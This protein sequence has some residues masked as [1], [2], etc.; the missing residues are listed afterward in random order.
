MT[1]SV[2]NLLCGIGLFLCGIFLIS[3]HT[4]NAFGEK[5]QHTLGLLTKNRFTGMLTG[6]IVT[7]IIQSSSAT[8]VMAVSFVSSG[9][10]NLSQATGIVMG[11][12]IG[13][14]V[15]SLLIAFNF[16]K[17]APLAIFF[18][19]AVKIFAKKEQT[20]HICYLVTG[21]GLLFLGMNTMSLA[22]SHLKESEA[23]LRFVAACDGKI[24]CIL[25]GFIM[26][27]ILQSSSATVGI[28]QA[29][30]LSGIVSTENA[31]YI[32]FGQNIGA[33]IPTMLSTVGAKKEAKQ[34]ALVHL[35]FNVIGTVVFFIVFEIVP[36]P[37]FIQRIGNPSMQVSFMHIA[38][39]VLSTVI[40]L[41]FGDVLI[42]L[43][44]GYKK[45]HT[46]KLAWGKKSDF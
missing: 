28:L 7:G 15:T 38:F 37:S 32:I 25:T 14:T 13:T 31:L 12:N 19:V 40:L 46:K 39:N 44:G 21:F 45:P 36:L 3:E 16:S 18:G 6:L 22:F 27:A 9:L 10:M 43:S 5:L 23:F 17:I 33:V 26:T 35:L 34:V 24:N 1:Q 30:A 11:A 41:P 8:T 29:L 20:K 2:I 42:Y 4:E